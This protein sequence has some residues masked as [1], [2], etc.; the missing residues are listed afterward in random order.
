MKKTLESNERLIKLVDHLLDLSHMERGKMEF[1]FKKVSFQE[2]V[3]NAFE[4]MKPQAETKGLKFIYHRPPKGDFLV[5][6]DD[7]KLHQVIVNLMD[8]AI[9]YTEKGK[10]EL[11]LGRTDH[12]ITFSIKDTGIGILPEEKKHLFKRFIRG[13][14]VSRL[15]TEGVGLGLYVARLIIE[16]HRGQIGGESEGEGKGSEFWVKLSAAK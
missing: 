10:V 16:A 11:S 9:R 4:E 5:E 12:E 13:K 6:A 7:G 8:N 3:E 14:K 1:E 2:I 15:W